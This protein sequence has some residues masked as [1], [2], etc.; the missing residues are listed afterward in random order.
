MAHRPPESPWSKALRMAFGPQIRA[1]RGEAPLGPVFWG[2]AVLPSLVLV[3]IYVDA[4]Y[5][6]DPVVEQVALSLFQLHSGWALVSIWR[7]ADNATP[8]WDT[9]A[10]LVTIAWA[11]NAV[12]VAG[13]L[14]LDLLRR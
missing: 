8:P 12:L 11:V 3:L 6:R 10:R 2:Q 9:I 4:L 14:Q 7:C 5:R 1:W 13:F